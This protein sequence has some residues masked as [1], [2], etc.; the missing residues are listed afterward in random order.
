MGG[1]LRACTSWRK[2]A[3]DTRSEYSE[4][5]GEKG[6]GRDRREMPPSDTREDPSPEVR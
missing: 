4:L 2:E 3:S 5:V 1:R 6:N